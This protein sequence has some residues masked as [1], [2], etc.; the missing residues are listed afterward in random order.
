MTTALKRLRAVLFHY[1]YK[2]WLS[3]HQR[4]KRLKKPG[5]RKSATLCVFPMNE[6]LRDED[7]T[8]KFPIKITS[9]LT[10]LEGQVL[11]M[12]KVLSRTC[13]DVSSIALGYSLTL[14]QAV[15]PRKGSR[16]DTMKTE[17][18]PLPHDANRGKRS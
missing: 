2:P 17:T 8:F 9:V 11:K 16:H 3:K 18:P 10:S 12:S 1:P 14:L 6:G 4:L 13:R 7:H 15:I 5:V